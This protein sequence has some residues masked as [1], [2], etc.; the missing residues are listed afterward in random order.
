MGENKTITKTMFYDAEPL[1]FERAKQLRKNMT[2]AEK[3]LWKY[4]KEN[5]ILGYR[6]KAQHPINRF[7]ADFYCHMAKLVVEIDGEIHESEE[8]MEKDESRT[9][10][11]KGLE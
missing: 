9:R 2:V 7:I 10:K 4:L 5:K 1:I 6:F 3:K 11:L 8:A